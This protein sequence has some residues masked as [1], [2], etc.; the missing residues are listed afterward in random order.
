MQAGLQ[1]FAGKGPA[2]TEPLVPV[3]LTKDAT[4]VS[5]ILQNSTS[6]EITFAAAGNA[7]AYLST[8]RQFQAFK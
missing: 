4:S 7:S 2:L 3:S 8:V 5:A 6:V 1:T